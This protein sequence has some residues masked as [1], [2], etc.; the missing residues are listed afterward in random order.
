MFEETL[1]RLQVQTYFRDKFYS[2][3]QSL[4]SK[5]VHRLVQAKPFTKAQ[6]LLAMCE[7]MTFK[8]KGKWYEMEMKKDEGHFQEKKSSEG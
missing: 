4:C 5:K 3:P 2:C 8:K 1:P 7:C 6:L